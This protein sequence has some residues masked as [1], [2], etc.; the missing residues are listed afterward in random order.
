MPRRITSQ[1]C[2]VC[3]KDDVKVFRYKKVFALCSSHIELAQLIG[4][5]Y[6]AFTLSQVINA[7]KEHYEKEK[8]EKVVEKSVSFL[9]KQTWKALLKR[10]EM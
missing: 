3:S 1:S 6:P 4:E 2:M 7:C 10:R 8:T 9:D 5:K